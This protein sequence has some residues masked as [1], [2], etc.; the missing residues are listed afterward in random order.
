MS[1]DAGKAVET[2]HKDVQHLRDKMVYDKIPRKTALARGWKVIKTRWMD[3]NKGDVEH[4]IYRSRFVGKEFNTGEI[5]GI[6]AGTPPLEALR[7]LIHEAATVR[8]GQNVNHKVI[9]V[10]DVARAFFEAPSVRPICVDIPEEDN[11]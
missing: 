6:F 5:E 2:R 11:N 3:I 4:P 7:C 10:N 1:L 9:M 8:N